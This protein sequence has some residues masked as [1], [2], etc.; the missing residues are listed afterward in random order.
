[1]VTLTRGEK[2]GKM[3]NGAAGIRPEAN[4]PSAPADYMVSPETNK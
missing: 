3:R 2:T 1:M 4:R